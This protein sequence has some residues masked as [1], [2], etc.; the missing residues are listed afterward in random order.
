MIVLASDLLISSISLTPAIA[1]TSFKGSS[2][3]SESLF[4]RSTCG[5]VAGRSLLIAII[6][7][8]SSLAVPSLPPVNSVKSATPAFSSTES[9]PIPIWSDS[10][11]IK[12]SCFSLAGKCPLLSSYSCSMALRASS[13]VSSPIAFPESNFSRWSSERC[14]TRLSNSAICLGVGFSR[15]RSSAWLCIARNS[16]TKPSHISVPTVPPCSILSKLSSIS[17]VNSGENS[18]SES[19]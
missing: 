7:E 11:T 5:A 12:S 2:C 19:P 18:P 1:R 14:T 8:I 6:S 17:D 16:S 10:L 3:C 9:K 4:T 15:L 13:P